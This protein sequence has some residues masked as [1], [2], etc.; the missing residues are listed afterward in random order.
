MAAPEIML[1]I[2]HKSFSIPLGLHEN[3]R[4]SRF[5]RL[6]RPNCLSCQAP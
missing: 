2:R 5:L 6:K 4:D 1:A 3:S